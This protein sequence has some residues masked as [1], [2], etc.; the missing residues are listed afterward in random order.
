MRS[1]TGNDCDCARSHE[2][3]RRTDGHLEPAFDE[4]PDLLI[5]MPMLMNGRAFFEREMHEAHVRTIEA[6]AFPPRSSLAHRQL[7][8]IDERHRPPSPHSGRRGLSLQC[9]ASAF[10]CRRE[11]Q[12]RYPD[13]WYSNRGR[14][15]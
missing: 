7:V 4:I 15:K 14:R 10:G 1:V 13:Q 2:L 3:H 8:G 12:T 11:D 9:E 6:A 5:R